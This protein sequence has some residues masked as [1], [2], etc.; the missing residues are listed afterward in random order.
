MAIKMTGCTFSGN[1]KLVVASSKIKTIVKCSDCKHVLL[2]REGCVDFDS[3]KLT[4][5]PK[6]G[7]GSVDCDI[8]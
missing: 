6:C 1:Q 4:P 3:D 2:E 7:C 5:C 8:C